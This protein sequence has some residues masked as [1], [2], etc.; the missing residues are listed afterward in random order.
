MRVHRRQRP[1]SRWWRA[2][3][4]LLAGLVFVASGTL[5]ACDPTASCASRM[6]TLPAPH[7]AVRAGV[8]YGVAQ[9][10][11]AWDAVTGALLWQTSL[12]PGTTA[13]LSPPVV[14]G[15]A[16]YVATGDGRVLAWRATTGVLLWRSRGL[17]VAPAAAGATVPPPLVE[18]GVLYA[19]AGS[20][21]IAAWRLR[22][23]ALLWQSPPLAVTS[24]AAVGIAV[25]VA[26]GGVIYYSAAN[27]VIAVRA[28][29]GHR[30]WQ[31][32]TPL[33]SIRLSPPLVA[34]SIPRAPDGLLVVS[35]SDDSV[36]AFD[37]LTGAFAW[38]ASSVAI[39]GTSN[40]TSPPA[41]MLAGAALYL[42]T[43]DGWVAALRVA[44]G[45]ALWRAQVPGT[46]PYLPPQLAGTSGS[47]TV[48]LYTGSAD[49]IYAVNLA[50]GQFVW[51]S[52]ANLANPGA[53]LLVAGD[54][55]YA[56]GQGH[57]FAWRARNGDFLWQAPL[58]G[59][60]PLLATADGLLY[61]GVS[62]ATATCQLP[63]S[64]NGVLVRW[65]GDG[66]VLWRAPV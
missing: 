32:H 6:V 41:L 14:T 16:I 3:M 1:D 20:S 60:P 25:P 66:S 65:S 7:L 46:A 56:S 38:H 23:G 49:G 43:A 44:D 18:G 13:E 12:P 26:T 57:L 17:A 11:D 53:T 15:A 5:A 50:N 19:G 39:P 9:R 52:G 28:R 33:A 27:Q 59:A 58:A 61:A 10:L 35:A 64:A 63:G 48:L 51:Q 4:R 37:A 24:G 36:Y 34:G 2:T 42:G 47:S 30:L 54:T 55:A 21:A 45:R 22:D 29:D 31:A 40:G 8:L 62:G